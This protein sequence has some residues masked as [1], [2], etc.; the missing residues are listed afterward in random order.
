MWFKLGP[1]QGNFQ[2]CSSYRV[3][4]GKYGRY[5][6]IS[7]C[8]WAQITAVCG[9]AHCHDL[10]ST[11]PA[12]VLV[13]LKESTAVNVPK[14]EVWMLWQ[15]KFL[16]HP[17]TR[18]AWYWCLILTFIFLLVLDYYWRLDIRRPRSYLQLLFCWPGYSNDLA[19][20]CEQISFLFIFCLL[21]RFF[22]PLLHRLS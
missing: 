18:S 9:K 20:R 8:Y 14:I 7:I 17:K 19:A 16:S 5:S 2:F 1:F 22:I 21:L 11:C 15:N 10:E 3:I 4:S 6:N 13:C 12:K